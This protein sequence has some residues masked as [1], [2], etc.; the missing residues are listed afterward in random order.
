[1]FGVSMWWQV[2]GLSYKRDLDFETSWINKAQITERQMLQYLY[3]IYK[4][5]V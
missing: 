4:K 1:M 5:Y 3:S 2:S